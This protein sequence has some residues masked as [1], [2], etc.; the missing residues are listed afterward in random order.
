M[1]ERTEGSNKKFDAP[2]FYVRF[3]KFRKTVERG[4]PGSV[5][6]ERTD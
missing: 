6:N 1:K 2:P 3:S 4:Y 5:R